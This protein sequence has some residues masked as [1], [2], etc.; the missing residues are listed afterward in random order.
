MAR[1]VVTVMII[2]GIEAVFLPLVLLNLHVV[3]L[4]L[5]SHHHHAENGNHESNSDSLFEY[6][7]EEQFE[8]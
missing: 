2:V 3:L 7:R 5:G 8:S 4:L 1:V 6:S